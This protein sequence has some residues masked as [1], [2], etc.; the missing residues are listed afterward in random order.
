MKEKN[1]V[2]NVVEIKSFSP[3][4][5]ENSYSSRLLVDRESV[6]SNLMVMN[7]FTLKGNNQ[8]Y[9]GNHGVGFDEIYF[10]L[11]GKTLLYLQ[12][13]DSDNYKEHQLSQWSYAFIKGGRGH[14][15]VNPY[16]EDLVLLTIMAK[17]PIKGV[18]LL[19][20]ERKAEW[21]TSFKLVNSKD[22]I[23]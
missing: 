1:V 22:E 17:H 14:Y 9:K 20:D 7:E 13:I 12:E 4:G 18:N 5:S 21:G 19:Y 11:S 3:S 8:T 23:R 2:Y 15:M 6:G 16:N 10:V